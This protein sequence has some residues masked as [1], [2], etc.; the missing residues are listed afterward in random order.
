MTWHSIVKVKDHTIDIHDP[1]F[2]WKH[3]KPD[4]DRYHLIKPAN[5]EERM[6]GKKKKSP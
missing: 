6:K 2:P 5:R 4:W 1:S 3:G